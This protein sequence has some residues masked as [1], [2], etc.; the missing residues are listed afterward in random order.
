MLSVSPC[1]IVIRGLGGQIAER[2]PKVPV[3]GQLLGHALGALG[4]GEDLLD[5]LQEQV[6][7]LGT[8][9]ELLVGRRP[10]LDQPLEESLGDDRGTASPRSG[11]PCERVGGIASR[12]RGS[13]AGGCPCRGVHPATAPGPSR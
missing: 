11:T 4:V 8:P 2:E 10:G 13:G 6:E 7:D 3:E 5:V 12:R 1:Q 9:E